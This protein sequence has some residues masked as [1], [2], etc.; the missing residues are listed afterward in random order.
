[1]GLGSDLNTRGVKVKPWVLM[2]LSLAS[3]TTIF[4]MLA[5]GQGAIMDIEPVLHRNTIASPG[6]RGRQMKDHLPWL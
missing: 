1:M 6:C 2:A 3:S 4:P 5:V